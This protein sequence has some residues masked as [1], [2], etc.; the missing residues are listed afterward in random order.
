MEPSS[1]AFTVVHSKL[2]YSASAWAEDGPKTAKNT[3]TL[4]KSQAH[5]F[6]WNIT[7]VSTSSTGEEEYRKNAR[8][9]LTIKV[10]KKVGREFEIEMSQDRY[11]GLRY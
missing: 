1:T 2:I 11:C 3:Y 10:A 7:S 9:T 8:E 6:T 5:R 4:N